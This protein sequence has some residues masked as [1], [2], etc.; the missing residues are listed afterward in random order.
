MLFK[1]VIQKIRILI[2]KYQQ[3]ALDQHGE[4]HSVSR[5]GFEVLA[6]TDQVDLINPV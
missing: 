1:C 2:F 3:K 5:E 6:E 4:T